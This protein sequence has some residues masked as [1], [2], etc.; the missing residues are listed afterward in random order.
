MRRP[1]GPGR[2][3]RPGSDSLGGGAVLT[4]C[5]GALYAS[6]GPFPMRCQRSFGATRSEAATPSQAGYRGRKRL[7]V[8]SLSLWAV[9]C[10]WPASRSRRAT[11]DWLA[12][13][14]GYYDDYGP[15]FYGGFVNE[16]RLRSGHPQ[17]CRIDSGRVGFDGIGAGGAAPFAHLLARPSP[18]H[19]LGTNSGTGGRASGTGHGATQGAGHASSGGHSGGGH[20]RRSAKRAAHAWLEPPLPASP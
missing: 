5:W 12:A 19:V 2:R 1:R 10:S 8:S 4:C 17:D 6:L 3:R 7:P 16:C 9:P 20:G 18:R 13:G 15:A 11:Y 14:G